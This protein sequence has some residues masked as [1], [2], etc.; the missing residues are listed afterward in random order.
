MPTVRFSPGQSGDP[1]FGLRRDGGGI[2]DGVAVPDAVA[3]AARLFDA[4]RGAA[5]GFA[6]AAADAAPAAARGSA[7]TF[8]FVFAFAAGFVAVDFL[9]DFPA[10]GA[11]FFTLDRAV[12]LVLAFALPLTAFLAFFA[13]GRFLVLAG[14]TRIPRMSLY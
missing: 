11:A 14:V 5:A 1:G 13:A 4:E 2:G 9:E 6:R 12:G 8:A 7:F 3:A 10:L